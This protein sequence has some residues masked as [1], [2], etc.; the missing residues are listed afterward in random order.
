[1]IA[2]AGLC[3]T[4]DDLFIGMAVGTI[5]VVVAIAGSLTVLPALQAW[6]GPRAEP[7]RIPVLGAGL[8][9]GARVGRGGRDR[10][11]RHRAEDG[12]GG[13][14]AAGAHL[15]RRR[16]PPAG[17]RHRGRR[18]A[19]ARNRRPVGW[20]RD[21]LRVQPA[22]SGRA[23]YG[24][25]T[26]IF[27]DGRLQGPL[28]YTAFGGIIYWV[29]LFMFVFLFGISMDY[30]V[31]ILSWIRELWSR[32]RAVRCRHRRTASS[33]G[34]VSSAALIMVAVFSGCR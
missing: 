1:M 11:R 24:L 26:L 14:R 9:A 31:F 12:G 8:L 34:V 4:G 7:G 20:E 19:S 21:R 10:D 16:D 18:R 15:A 27:Q 13:R 29:P 25:V 32:C 5:V 3:L 33:A 6:L 17:D 22:V 23:A 28:G 30:H 2:M